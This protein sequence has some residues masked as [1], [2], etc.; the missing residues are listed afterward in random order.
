V[1]A[2]ADEAEPPAGGRW[3]APGHDVPATLPGGRWG[4]VSGSSYAA[5]HVTGLFALLR[6][7]TPLATGGPR[8]C[9]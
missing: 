1:V 7:R 2:V 6:E 8:R 3:L 5:A 9:A 4:L